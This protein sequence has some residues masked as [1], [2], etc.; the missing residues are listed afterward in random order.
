MEKNS[1]VLPY[2][3]LLDLTP[4]YHTVR[5]RTSSFQ[6]SLS[7]VYSLGFVSHMML[8]LYQ[9]RM[10]LAAIFQ[11]HGRQDSEQLTENRGRGRPQ[12]W[13]NARPVRDSEFYL[14]I[15]AEGQQSLFNPQPCREKKW[16]AKV[17]VV[18][19][20]AKALELQSQKGLDGCLSSYLNL[21][22]GANINYCM[23]LLIFHCYSSS[24]KYQTSFHPLFHHWSW[25]LNV[26]E[27]WQ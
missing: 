12:G 1:I 5:K 14:L 19:S 17:G 16:K 25:M 24:S 9:T 18:K 11:H 13:I 10:K 7:S 20:H 15:K 8:K 6:S 26:I 23:R 27:F 22:E 2:K 3:Y 4:L 21:R